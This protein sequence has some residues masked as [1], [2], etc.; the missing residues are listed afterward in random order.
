MLAKLT[1]KNQITLPKKIMVHFPQAHYFDVAEAEGTL[2]LTPVTVKPHVA[3]ASVVRDKLA[4]LGI[5][6]K[7]AKAALRWARS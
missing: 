7:E 5:D 1:S 3:S 6:A 2:V 4:R